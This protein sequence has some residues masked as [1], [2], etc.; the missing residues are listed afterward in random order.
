MLAASVTRCRSC[1]RRKDLAGILIGRAGYIDNCRILAV[2]CRA[3]IGE[4]RTQLLVQLGDRPTAPAGCTDALRVSTQ[5]A[6]SSSHFLQPPSSSLDVL[7]AI[8]IEHPGTPGC[9]PVGS[10]P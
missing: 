9:E 3:N 1:G 10:I 6:L 7:D 8:D 2:G 5:T 4:A